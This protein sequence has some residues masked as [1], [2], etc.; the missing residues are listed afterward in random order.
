M[1]EKKGRGRWRRAGGER[2]REMGWDGDE[3]GAR[4]EK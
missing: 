3:K 2:D 1:I 4:D